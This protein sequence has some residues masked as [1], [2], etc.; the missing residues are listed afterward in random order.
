MKRILL[1]AILLLAMVGTA[2]AYNLYLTCPDKIQVGASLKCSI[3]SNFPPGTTF[4]FVLYQSGYTATQIKKQQITIQADKKTLYVTQD[5]TGLPGGTYKAEV[6][7]INNDEQRFSSDSIIFKQIILV[8][9]S[10]DIDITSPVT[11]DL[12]D[13]LRIEGELKNGGND[14]IELEVKGPDGRIFGPQWVGTKASIKNNAGV[15]TQKVTVTSGGEYTVDFSDASGYVG[16]K[17][18]MVTAP[19]VATTAVPVTTIAAPK[20]TRPATTVPTAWPTTTAQS[21]LSPLPVV[22]GL[23]VAG[24]LAVLTMRRLP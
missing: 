16:T 12:K 2:S 4:N 20:T 19:T 8:D 11:Q 15:F 13:A 10:A 23:G 9:R 22:A 21:P 3:E 14:G 24:I 17:R 18:F 7:T 1:I 6:Q 5:T